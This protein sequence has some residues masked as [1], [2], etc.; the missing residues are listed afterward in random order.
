[1]TVYQLSNEDVAQGDAFCACG[2]SLSKL[3]EG[4]VKKYT[5]TGRVKVKVNVT[6]WKAMKAQRGVD[7]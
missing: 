6:L 4:C 7:V 2:F 3:P 1:M 5:Y